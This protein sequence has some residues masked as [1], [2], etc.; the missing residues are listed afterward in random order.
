LKGRLSECGVDRDRLPKLAA[1]AA[2]QWTGTFNPRELT[3]SD[4]L[5][6]YEQ[7]F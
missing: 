5:Q 4:W 2:K 6:L 7:A 3:Q 1:E